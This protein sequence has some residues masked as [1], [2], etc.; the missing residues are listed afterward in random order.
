MM[1]PIILLFL[2]NNFVNGLFGEISDLLV[3]T[4]LGS[5]QGFSK[6]SSYGRAYRAFEGIPYA[7]P[8]V[9]NLRFEPPNDNGP[10]EDTLLATSPKSGCVA[11]TH[12]LGNPS[13]RITG[14][15]DCLYLNIY[16]PFNQTKKESKLPVLFWIHGGAFQFGQGSHEGP[17]YIMNR[18]LVFVTINYR[19]NILGFMSTGDGVVPGNMGLKDQSLA[20]RWV[21][22]NI[23]SFGGDPNR[24]T[25]G[26]VSAGG[27]STHYHYL[28]PM[29]RGLFQGGIS[30]SGTALDCW[31]Q[32]ENSPEKAKKVGSLQGCPTNSTKEM[33]ECL[34]SRPA[35]SI[36][37]L[38]AQ[39]QPWWFNPFTPFGPV[40]EENSPS[41]FISRSPIEIITSGDAADLP[42]ITS[43][44][45]EEG[46]YP[47][48]EFIE[49]KFMAELD[50]KWEELAP[51]LL[52]F[53]YTI[54]QSQHARIAVKIRKHY[55]GNRKIQ[56]DTA[57]SLIHM[58]G[59]RLFSVDAAKAAKLMAKINRSP[60]WFYYYN[61]RASISLTDVFNVTGNYGVSHSDDAFT[62]IDSGLPVITDQPTLN[63]QKIFLDIIES[64]L[65]K[66]SPPN[67]IRWPEVAASMEYLNYLHIAGPEKLNATCSSDFAEEKFWSCINFDENKPTV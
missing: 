66:G 28:S 17:L 41:A 26:G 63:M 13:G 55:L 31:T 64:F 54:P 34:K 12:E 19:L 62:F 16:T 25:I 47:I 11:Y 53:N 45:S 20:L 44:T 15:E 61:Y 33:V 36:V 57:K 39:F 59:D 1:K 24:I 40:V 52:D 50:E 32:T 42:W 7:K 5:V 60:V 27:A 3:E 14:E 58:V 51:H 43:V 2:L 30:V 10:W 21:H 4:A 29:S 9:G 8:P 46:L 49:G 56:K 35:R 37:Q 38:V 65:Q 6:I 67:N 22:E 48:V 23:E 18:D